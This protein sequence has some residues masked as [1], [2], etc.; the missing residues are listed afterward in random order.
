MGSKPSKKNNTQ[1]PN[2]PLTLQQSNRKKEVY[3][4]NF[5]QEIKNISNLLPQYPYVGM[6][7]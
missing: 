1:I 2:I 7:T 5:I 3:A 6:D 4:D